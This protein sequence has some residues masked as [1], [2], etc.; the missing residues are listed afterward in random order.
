MYGTQSA[1]V[2]TAAH[3]KYISSGVMYSS[4]A[5][6]DLAI[7]CMISVI[8]AVLDDLATAAKLSLH[9]LPG[10]LSRT[11]R[12]QRM[13]NLIGIEVGECDVHAAD[14]MPLPLVA[15]YILRAVS[16]ARLTVGCEGHPLGVRMGS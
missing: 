7:S 14:G 3:A 10:W 16:I 2:R 15:I 11:R 1:A 6:G 5:K 4:R 12:P 9:Y 13:P 8:R